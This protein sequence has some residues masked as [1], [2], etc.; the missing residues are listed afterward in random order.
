MRVAPF[1]AVLPDLRLVT[2]TDHFFSTVKEDYSKYASVGFFHKAARESLYVYRIV[3]DGRAHW[4]YVGTV[5]ISE[6]LEGRIKK[7]ELTL[8]DKEQQQLRLL[9]ERG[10]QVKPVLLAWQGES[11]LAGFAR[12]WGAAHEPVLDLELAGEGSRHTLWAIADGTVL[13][14]LRQ[15]FAE[16]VAVTYIADGHHRTS[17]V[18]LLYEQYAGQPAQ[19][20]FEW[21]LAALFPADQLTIRDYNRVVDTRNEIS[22]TRL[23]AALSQ[24]CDIRLM[25]A[26]HKPRQPHQLTLFINNEWYEL[27]WKPQYIVP[28]GPGL[29]VLDVD[30]FNRYVLGEILGIADVRSDRRLSYVEGT[31]GLEGLKNKVLKNEH[32]VGFCLYPLQMEDFIRVSDAGQTLPPKST[33][34]E[35][36]MKNGLIAMEIGIECVRER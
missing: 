17:V 36:R 15:W 32:R 18:A 24:Y 11:R 22:F 35:P 21:L 27:S 19:A 23:M 12:E 28:M 20:R 30:L 9:L 4:G 10:A 29:P 7:H 6:Y 34:F 8:A 26:P 3:Q 31:K 1:Q 14:Q 5:H 33:W 25:E 16:E 13:S 2:S